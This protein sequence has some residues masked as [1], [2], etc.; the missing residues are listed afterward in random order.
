MHET[1][2]LC[3]SQLKIVS[4]CKG[5]R[6]DWLSSDIVYK[7]KEDTFS[8]SAS[9]SH[10]IPVQYVLLVVVVVLL[11]ASLSSSS[12]LNDGYLWLHAC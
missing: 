11:S 8:G 5:I 6:D 7:C 3:Q 2:G 12:P 4:F 10:L 9:A 1:R